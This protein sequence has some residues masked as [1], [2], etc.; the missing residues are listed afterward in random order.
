MA[1]DLRGGLSLCLSGAAYWSHD[2]G[3]FAGDGNPALY[4]R[5]VAF[6]L[7]ST[8]SRL[9]GSGAYRVPWLFD[10][11]SV[12]VLKSFTRLKNRLFPYLFSAARDAR[13]HG[14]P[15][16]R[17][18]VFEYPDDPACR[19]LEHQYMLGSSLLVA[20]VMRQDDVAEYYLP[21][22]RWTHLQTNQVVEGGQWRHETLDFMRVPLFVRENTIL[23][24][25]ADEEQPQ[26]RLNDPLTLHLFH[27][28]DGAD[29]TLRVA[30]SDGAGEAVFNC[31]RAGDKLAITSD[32]RAKSVRL[33]LRSTRAV[34]KVTGGKV[35][36]ETPEGTPIEW[37]DASKPITLTLND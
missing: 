18:M 24:I 8:H 16:M 31:R 15:V 13:E 22:G 25:G 17:A 4:K 3:G 12:A 34:E 11:E 26:W 27:V 33:M 19:Y 20:P 29:L 30:T 28:A 5:W 9:H 7:L 1:E 37:P 21:R 14:W 36:R 10:E 35:L 6:G 23:P 2:I 32:G